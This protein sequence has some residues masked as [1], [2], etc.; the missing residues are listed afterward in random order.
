[1]RSHLLMWSWACWKKGR[2]LLLYFGVA[3]INAT[4]AFCRSW[5]CCVCARDAGIDWCEMDEGRSR[6]FWSVGCMR[7]TSFGYLFAS[8]ASDGENGWDICLLLRKGERF[9][10]IP[11]VR[12]I[13][14]HTFQGLNESWVCQRLYFHTFAMWDEGKPEMCWMRLRKSFIHDFDWNVDQVAI[15][16]IILI[17]KEYIFKLYETAA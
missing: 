10:S 7:L 11:C 17:I 4:I 14:L 13:C 2:F 8:H 9:S 5:N 3:Y 1:M 12:L 6:D 16:K 15:F